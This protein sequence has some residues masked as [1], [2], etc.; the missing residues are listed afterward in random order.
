MDQ[1]KKSLA[2]LSSDFEKIYAQLDIDSDRSK[3]DQLEEEL[4]RPEIWN[5]PNHATS[6]NKKLNSLKNSL[7]PWL[8]L[9][10]QLK[11]MHE[12]I[13]LGGEELEKASTIRLVSRNG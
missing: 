6:L 13:E 7:Q 12:L 4:A 10:M 5:N 3:L 2:I 11:D 8:A 9:K 1:I